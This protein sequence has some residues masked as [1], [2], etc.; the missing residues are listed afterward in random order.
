MSRAN[1]PGSLALARS[2]PADTQPNREEFF[3]HDAQVRKSLCKIT[4]VLDTTSRLIEAPKTGARTWATVES[5]E[6]PVAD[7]RRSSGIALSLI[8]AHPRKPW[9]TFG[10]IVPDRKTVISAAAR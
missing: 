2:D 1:Q 5:H 3:Q 4:S 9:P 8:R 7:L 6:K 10:G